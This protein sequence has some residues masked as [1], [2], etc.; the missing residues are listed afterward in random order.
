MKRRNCALELWT[1]PFLFCA[2]SPNQSAGCGDVGDVDAVLVVGLLA[3]ILPSSTATL[4]LA[5]INYEVVA[6][7]AIKTELQDPYNVLDNW[8]INLVKWNS[9][10]S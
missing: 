2:C 1:S 10:R 5:G 6:L 4:S 9:N 3:M 8:D 7:M